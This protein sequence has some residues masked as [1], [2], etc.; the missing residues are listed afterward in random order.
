MSDLWK[1]INP[2]APPNVPAPVP[3]SVPSPGSGVVTEH[4][5]VGRSVVIKGEVSGNE[6]LFIDGS[7]EGSI[8]FPKHRVTVGRG[9]KVT[10]DI[11]AQDVVVMGSMKGNIYCSDLL[12]IRSESWIQG[13]IV[14]KRIRIDDGA[15][16][17]GSVEIQPSPKGAPAEPPLAKAA[18][19][20]QSAKP[21]AVQPAVPPLAPAGPE[22]VKR[23]PGSS[24][25]FKPV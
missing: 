23:A 3:A 15:V 6:A 14:T 20:T 1:S 13:E 19:A 17:K 16:L 2:P 9:S 5:T 21:A 22:S 25:L 7:V 8:R 11:H 18:A 4:A 24:V 12:D 10:A